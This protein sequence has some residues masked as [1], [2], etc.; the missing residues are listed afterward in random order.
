M[1]F[2]SLIKENLRIS[3]NSIKSNLL[4]TILTIMIIALGIMALVGIMTA[5]DSIKNSISSEFASMGANT[6]SITSRGMRVHVGGKQY[7]RKS[8]SHI[9]Y[10]QAKRFKEEYTFPASVATSI[11][12]SGTATIKFKSE[13]TNPNVRVI[14]I[15][16]NYMYNNGL[17]VEKGRGFSQS[18][19][20][21]SRNIAVIGN[22]IAKKLFKNSLNP[23]EKIITVGSG[24]YRV[25][26]VLE[27]KG[28]GFGGGDD[29]SVFLPISNVRQNYARP[30]MNYGI[31]VRPNDNKLVD[32]AMDEAE[33]TFR[34]VR[35][36]SV[37]DESDFN[38]VKSDNLAKILLENMKNV[39]F[40]AGIIGAITLFG[41]AIGLMNIL[42]VSVSERTREIGTRKAIGAKSWLIKQQFLF[43]AI[44]ISQ[45]GGL[46]GIVL[47]IAA[48]NLVSK[49]T[50]GGFVAP[51]EWI[52]GGVVICSIV[53]IAA[54]YI[55]AVK[56]SKLDPIEA[57]RYE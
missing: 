40:V 49:M 34:I 54:G 56:A 55:P 44:L 25:I 36:L 46:L 48:G 37:K 7:R 22:G 11:Y 8:H 50:G 31:S 41:A 1:K 30:N 5:I 28:S 16:E 29:Q 51:W 13:K 39:T 23:I 47:G 4:R 2:G 6:F 20:L 42:L 18:E 12:A 26:G 33:G 14:G 3:I 10:H 53:G 27:S 35:K 43:E 17:S 19:L 9:S 15:D 52:I 24:K 32:A 21:M 45:L 57:L 38:I